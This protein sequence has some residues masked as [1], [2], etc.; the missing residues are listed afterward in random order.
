MRYYPVPFAAKEEERLV[1]NLT[2]REVLILAV[3]IALGLLTAWLMS[4]ALHTFII[5]CSPFGLPSV[6]IAVLLAFIRVKKNDCVMTL[7]NYMLRKIFYAQRP[8]HYLKYREDC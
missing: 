3:G 6:G 2:T 4:K 8:R 1:Y 7:D 5:F